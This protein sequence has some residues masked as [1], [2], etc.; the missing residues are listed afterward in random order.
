MGA[1]LVE[2]GRIDFAVMVGE[3]QHLVSGEFD[4]ARLMHVHMACACRDYAGILRCDGVDY[5][6][7]GLRATY[8]EEICA[9]GQAHAS[10]I[11]AFALSQMLSLP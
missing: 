6:L 8:Q 9:S 1:V 3:R 2:F 10:R 4:G 7:V 11:L 5:G